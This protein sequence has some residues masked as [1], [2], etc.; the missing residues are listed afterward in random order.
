MRS[1]LIFTANDAV[2]NRFLLCRIVSVSTRKFH[3]NAGSV[4]E[5]INNVLEKIGTHTVEEMIVPPQVPVVTASPDIH[6]D[7]PLLLTTDLEFDL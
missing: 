2:A 1:D 3:D 7:V 5:T 4:H 6:T